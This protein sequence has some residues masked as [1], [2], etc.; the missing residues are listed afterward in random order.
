MV[1]KEAIFI[2]LIAAII[3]SGYTAITQHKTNS[4]N[5]TEDLQ[6]KSLLKNQEDSEVNLAKSEFGKT[7]RITASN[8]RNLYEM[9]VDRI[10]VNGILD[11]IEE[12]DCHWQAHDLGKMIFSKL[13]DL[14]DSIHLCMDRC[15]SGC[16]HGVLMEMFKGKIV[17]SSSVDEKYSH[18][19]LS[20]IEK[21]MKAL[22]S[23]DDIT[24][25]YSLGTCVHG[26]GHAI[27]S[28]SGYDINESMKLCNRFGTRPQAY[29]CATGAFMEYEFVSG[30]SDIKKSLH[31]PCDTL[32]EFPAA[33][34]RY[35]MLYTATSM[36]GDGKGM[37]DI[38]GECMRM[39]GMYRLGCFHGMGF[40]LLD[41]V[42]D[43]PQEIKV[44]CSFGN[45]DDRKMCIEGVVEKLADY[46]QSKAFESCGYLEG[47]DREVCIEAADGKMYR[48]DK[49]FSLYFTN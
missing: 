34:Y 7:F 8:H 47:A 28:L 11:V 17:P 16:L 32:E 35:K 18:I 9:Y 24:S 48:M 43:S 40:F 26:M 27:M 13:Q 25:V 31:Y 37:E 44:I 5:P 10:G 15:T 29:Y 12:E 1:Y 42:S 2:I 4:N 19:Y 33:C 49:D 6:Q 39:P 41:M 36:L 38:A 22:C 46:N 21:E 14:E 23:S 20:D 45:D 3:I 30:H